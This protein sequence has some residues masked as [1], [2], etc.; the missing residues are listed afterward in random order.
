MNT[1]NP[2]TVT[3]A[4]TDLVKDAE[5]L[6]LTAYLCPSNRLT[7][8]YG[9][10]LMPAWDAKLFRNVTT[11]ALARM[12]TESQ[13][14]KMVSRETQSRLRINPDQ[15]EQL[16][17]RDVAQTALF[18][19][20]VTPV[21]LTQHQFDALVS[22]IFNVGQG[23]YATSTLRKKL[24]AGDYEGAAGQFERWIYGTVDGK[25]VK[26]NGL[27]TRRAAERALFEGNP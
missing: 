4:C 1:N 8:G 16:L 25:K 18:L 7:I 5:K 23:N 26:L 12:I 20:S 13:R 19:R 21:S 24:H 22:F 9:H 6:R 10:V 11:E 17:A 27:I 14:I 15:A 3:T 2:S